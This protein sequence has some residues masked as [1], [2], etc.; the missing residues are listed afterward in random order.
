MQ[1][2][3]M[4]RL[5]RSAQVAHGQVAGLRRDGRDR[6]PAHA[7]RPGLDRQDD[8]AVRMG[9]DGYEAGQRAVATVGPR[10]VVQAQKQR[11]GLVAGIVERQG[12]G[13]SVAPVERRG[14]VEAERRP[15]PPPCEAIGF[16]TRARLA[17][18]R[19]RQNPV[20]DGIA[21]A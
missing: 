3:D 13:R 6:P 21:E 17:I 4:V 15:V 11:E 12:Q 18:L 10:V 16:E 5:H 20:Q 2:D 8:V 9:R 19:Q 14:G 1:G 7:G